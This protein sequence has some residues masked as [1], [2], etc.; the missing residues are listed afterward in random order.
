MKT[1]HRKSKIAKATCINLLRDA[2]YSRI[3]ASKILDIGIATTTWAKA[4]K[5]ILTG[6]SFDFFSQIYNFLFF[7]F[8]WN[9]SKEKNEL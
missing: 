9:F 3:Q 1:E 4:G 6:V 5:S 2:G 7:F 8:C